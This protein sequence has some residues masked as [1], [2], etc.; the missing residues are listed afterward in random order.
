MSG[1]PTTPS[2]ARA[3][4]THLGE[5][6]GTGW[7]WTGSAAEH[8]WQVPGI[9]RR[10]GLSQLMLPNAESLDLAASILKQDPNGQFEL[11]V[12]PAAW[13]SS[14]RVERRGKVVVP[15]IAIALDLALDDARGRELLSGWDPE[16][17]HRVW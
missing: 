14:H 8:A 5:A 3:L 13:L 1:D 9:R 4:Q 15:A 17:A 7:A 10:A 6:V 16:G 2:N 11:V 12:A